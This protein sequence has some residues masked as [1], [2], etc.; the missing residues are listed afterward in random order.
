MVSFVGQVTGSANNVVSMNLTWPTVSP[1]NLAI[2][3]WTMA[4][5]NVPASTPSGFTLLGNLDSTTGSCRAYVYYKLCSGSEDGTTLTLTCDGANRHVSALDVWGGTIDQSNPIPAFQMLAH[6]GAAATS[7]PCPQI[8]IPYNDCVVAAG[9]HERNSNGTSGWT[10]PT[11]YTERSDRANVAT[12]GTSVA[13]ADDGLASGRTAGQLVTPPN[14]TSTN[15]FSTAS[16]VAY[17][18]AISP[19]SSA[20]AYN[21][22]SDM[23]P[24]FF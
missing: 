9:I 14:F 11:G 3:S 18:L 4:N 8:T 5:T 1:G 6:A 23:F 24:F 19:D 20:A 10:P 22:N 21:D 12:G 16:R 2:V 7:T 13:V 17:T 15:A